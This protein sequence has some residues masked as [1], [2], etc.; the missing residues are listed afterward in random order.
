MRYRRA[1]VAGATY[2]ITANL[3]DRRSTFLDDHIDSL[4]NALRRVKSRHPFEI[5]AMVVLPDHM[6]LMLTLP[7]DDANFS[8]RIQL[9]KSTFSRSLPKVEPIRPSRAAKRER[10]IWQ[11]RFWEHL[12][13]DDLDFA[14]HVDY[15]HINPVKH[16][17]V[18]KAVD[19]PH[20]TIHRYIERGVVDANWSVDVGEGE[21][22][23]G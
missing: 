20:S 9:I 11:R 16:G 1:N 3:A 23:E 13:R 15:I 12:I 17:Y 14:N 2:F 7:P 4:R 8:M 5:D 22:G 19:W 21:H 18:K 6:H 10:G